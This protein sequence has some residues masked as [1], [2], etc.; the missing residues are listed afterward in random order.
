MMEHD[1]P[2]NPVIRGLLYIRLLSM[3]AKRA[4]NTLQHEKETLEEHFS[5]VEKLET[6]TGRSKIM[7]CRN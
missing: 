1:L 7:V 4:L 3:G 6:E 2:E 5:F